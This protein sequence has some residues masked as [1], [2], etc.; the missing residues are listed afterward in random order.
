MKYNSMLILLVLLTIG[1]G[2]ARAGDYLVL[3]L[4]GAD[5]PYHAAATRLAELRKGEIVAGDPHDLK[6]LLDVLKQ[7]EPRYVA[8]VVRPEDLDIN[9][10]R[11][12]LKMATQVDA[13]PFVDFAYGFITGDTPDVALALVEAGVKTERERRKAT[14]AVAAVG[15]Q[16]ILKSAVH[17]QQFPLRTRT[18]PQL[19]G[20]IAGGENFAGGRDAAFIKNLMPQLQGKSMVMFAGHGYPGEILGGPTWKDF[21]GL[22]FDGA[23]VLNIACY[24]GV[25]GRW[26]EDDQAAGVRRERTVPRGESVCLAALRTGPAAY[27]GYACPRPAGPE[28]FLDITALAAEGLS[29]GE[30]RRRDYNRVVLAHMA[31][32]FGGL[33]ADEYAD[34]DRVRPPRNV[35]RDLLLDMAT[36]GML[37]GDPAF[38][39]FV[40]QPGEAPVEVKTERAGEHFLVNVAVGGQHVFFQ[41]SEPLAT[42]GEEQLPTLRVMARVPL[43]DDHVAE[44]KVKDLRPLDQ[45]DHRRL[46]WAVEDDRGQRFLH[47]KVYFPQPAPEKLATLMAGARAV[48]D[49]KTTRDPDEAQTR[50]VDPASLE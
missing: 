40:A 46:V 22:K 33:R 23:V 6:P 16:S 28:L 43:G 26:F 47:L 42:W 14:L 18:L 37:F 9:L 35:V 38:T 11:T 12:F 34:G 15:D 7:K 13:D 30:A 49:V 10:A 39:P 41:C 36:G 32:G 25:T 2:R 20:Q 1:A 24:T 5:D 45:F 19:W 29:V 50:F 48:F 17:A 3:D 44:V 4:A 31:Q 8:V 21:E 27:V